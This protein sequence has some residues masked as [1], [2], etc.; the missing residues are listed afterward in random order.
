ME[1]VVLAA[2]GV[3]VRYGQF[4]GAGTYHAERPVDGPAIQIDEAARRTLELLD[5]PPGSVVTLTSP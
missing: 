3:V 4:Y 5:A 2:A 1:E